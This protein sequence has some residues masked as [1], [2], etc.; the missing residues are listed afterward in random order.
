MIVQC[1]IGPDPPSENI[2]MG[3]EPLMSR[4]SSPLSFVWETDSEPNIQRL[5]HR[6]GYPW[7]NLAK[8]YIT[9]RLIGSAIGSAVLKSR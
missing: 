6:I 9:T 1:I 2:H 8:Y 3:R 7:G 5:H 4:E